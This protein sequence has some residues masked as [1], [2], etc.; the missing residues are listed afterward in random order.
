MCALPSCQGQ[1]PTM[2]RSAACE[3]LAAVLHIS[4]A[5]AQHKLNAVAC[6]PADPTYHAS[7]RTRRLMVLRS[8][9]EALIWASL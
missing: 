8:S 1:Y 3:E 5:E 6:S 4:M 9:L 7:R 2:L